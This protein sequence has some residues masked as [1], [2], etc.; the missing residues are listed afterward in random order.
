[1][2]EKITQ[3]QVNQAAWAA[4]DTFRGAVDPAQYKDYILVMLFLKY[5]S[6][7]WNDHLQSYRK[8]FSGDE[9]RIRRRLERERFVLPQG[10]GSVL[11]GKGDQPAV[12]LIRVGEYRAFAAAKMTDRHPMI[13]VPSLHRA[14]TAL[15]V[16]G[17]IFPRV[18]TF[19]RH[20]SP[21]LSFGIG[22]SRP[23]EEGN[24]AICKRFKPD[25]NVRIAKLRSIC[26]GDYKEVSFVDYIAQ[27]GS[28]LRP[29][30]SN[31]ARK[32]EGNGVRLRY[33][34]FFFAT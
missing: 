5:I 19:F 7:L 4:C 33:V 17:N 32:R 29:L 25:S 34:T 22:N 16:F 18:K 27:G 12:D 24:T 31:I 10:G 15:Q 28:T 13:S 30:D 3:A 9:A 6:D 21:P 26:D 14:Q 1:M 20:R 11:L 8:Q 23:R 2:N